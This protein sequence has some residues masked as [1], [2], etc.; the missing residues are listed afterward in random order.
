MEQIQGALGRGRGRGRPILSTSS[1][2][3]QQYSPQSHTSEEFVRSS[4]GGED[5][6]QLNQDSLINALKSRLSETSKPYA[7]S[8][9]FRQH[10]QRKVVDANNNIRVTTKKQY[11][12][13]KPQFRSTQADDDDDDLCPVCDRPTG[14]IMCTWCK[15]V[16]RVNIFSFNFLNFIFVN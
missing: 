13:A 10:E 4:Q 15:S 5:T 7:S 6:S 12:K 8:H 11:K 1:K 2:P 14:N 16:W 9:S 3:N